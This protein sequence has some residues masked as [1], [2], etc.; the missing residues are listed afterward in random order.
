[1][2]T[3]LD[4]NDTYYKYLEKKDSI[5]QA[6]FWMCTWASKKGKSSN[7]GNKEESVNQHTVVINRSDHCCVG[8]TSHQGVIGV[9]VHAGGV[10]RTLVILKG[11]EMRDALRVRILKE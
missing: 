3:N 6:L 2:Y 11:S 10:V 1:M 9:R 8:V 7:T 5:E 4:L